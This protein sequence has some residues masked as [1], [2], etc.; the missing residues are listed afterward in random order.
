[1]T[2]GVQQFVAR[3]SDSGEKAVVVPLARSRKPPLTGKRK[4]NWHLPSSS[5][6]AAA[7]RSRCCARG[8]RQTGRERADEK[9]ARTAE[10]RQDGRN[11]PGWLAVAG[12]WCGAAAGWWRL[13]GSWLVLDFWWVSACRP[14][15]R[16]R[17]V[18]LWLQNKY[19]K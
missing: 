14:R 1:M 19:A 15:P 6:S 7:S 3:T 2:S 9:A 4:K 12:R 10:P 8:P 16:A 13:V 18:L 5:R 17:C 11:S